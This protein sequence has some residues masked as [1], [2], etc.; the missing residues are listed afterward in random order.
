ML[1]IFLPLKRIS[2]FFTR[3]ISF[4]LLRSAS[5]LI[6][7]LSGS[8]LT[9]MNMHWYHSWVMPGIVYPSSS[10]SQ[11][12][13]SKSRISL[14]HVQQLAYTMNQPAYTRL[15]ISN[16]IRKHCTTHVMIWWNVCVYLVVGDDGMKLW[17]GGKAEE[18]VDNVSWQF[19][20][21]LP[22]VPENSWHRRQHRV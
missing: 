19:N 22:V 5:F 18:D 4:F 21:F 14:S 17:E 2:C 15:N 11:P 9:R 6:S 16:N 13:H 8:I 10:S 1:L 7:A 12:P 20:A 3:V